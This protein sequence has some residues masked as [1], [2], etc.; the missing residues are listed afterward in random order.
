MADK[1]FV[2]QD[3]LNK[4]RDELIHLKEVERVN[5]AERL[6]E[7]ISFGD[8]SENSEYEEA[9]NVQ[10]QVEVRISE[11]ESQLKNI[12]IIDES[13]KDSSKVNMGDSVK[14]K[15]L[16]NNDEETYLIVGTTE[17]DILSKIPKISNESPVGKAIMGK[18]KGVSV[19]IKSDGGITEYKIL[20]IN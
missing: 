14:I 17:S 13:K 6:K 20:E 16:E 8:L 7:A 10:S 19:K 9:R 11:L 2:T 12:E 5:I 18:K 4:M 3:G 15:N 1:I